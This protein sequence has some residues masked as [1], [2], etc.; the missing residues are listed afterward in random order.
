MTKLENFDGGWW[1]WGCKPILVFSLSLS[2]AEQKTTTI[3]TNTTTTLM[4]FDT[5]EISLV[6]YFFLYHC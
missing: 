6:D 5:F 1:W 2:Q 3:T 4:G